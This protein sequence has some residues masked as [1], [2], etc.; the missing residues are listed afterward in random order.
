M[1]E[2]D[3]QHPD[4]AALAELGMHYPDTEHGPIKIE[5]KDL[6]AVTG[7]LGL[8]GFGFTTI[9]LSFHNVGVYELNS[10]IIGMARYYGGLAQFVAGIFE[11]TKGHTF[12]GIAFI[13]YASFWWTL[14]AIWTTPEEELKPEG[15][16]MG[17]F[18]LLWCV[19]TIVMFIGTLKSSW[20]LKGIFATLAITFL[21][22][23]IG[24]F[25]E[26]H[27]VTKVGGAVGLL[28]GALAMYTGLV[29][30]LDHTTGWMHGFY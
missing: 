20:S 28:C 2:I 3:D 8:L 26:Q 7:P 13:S 22:L 6:S 14:I 24:D 27:T 4:A 29:E 10:M 23:S 30:I 16:A 1:Q 5:L 11:L 18:L 25:T 15:K 9:L 19:F 17:L 21:F 12:S